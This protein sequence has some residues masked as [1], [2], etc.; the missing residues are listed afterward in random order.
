M[1]ATLLLTVA[2]CVKKPGDR[3]IGKW[4][5]SG[6]LDTAGK[7]IEAQF[8][9]AAVGRIHKTAEFRSDG[10]MVSAVT[11]GG[12]PDDNPWQGLW[13]VAESGPQRLVIESTADVDGRT[14]TKRAEIEFLS[15]DQIA[16]RESGDNI[17][18]EFV[19]DRVG[20]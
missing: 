15:D 5:G 8:V 1:L 2:G 10:T 14:V 20:R 3:L 19:L 11:V 7:S 9:G 18:T 6:K 17:L 16:L 12:L 13:R 4:E